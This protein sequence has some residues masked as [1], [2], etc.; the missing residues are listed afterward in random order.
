MVISDAHLAPDDDLPV[1]EEAVTWAKNHEFAVVFA[2]DILDLIIY[3]R[4]AYQKHSPYLIGSRR[5]NNLLALKVSIRR[6]IIGG[7]YLRGNHEGLMFRHLIDADALDI[8][9]GER[10]WRIEHGDRFA[11]DWGPLGNLFKRVAALALLFCPKLWLVFTKR[12][13][14]GPWK[15]VTGEQERYNHLTGTIW[16][17]ALTWAATHP[18]YAG[19]IIGHTHTEAELRLAHTAVY[20]A[21]NIRDGSAILV[22]KGKS[23]TLI[24]FGR[25]PCGGVD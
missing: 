4:R 3:G 16:A 14:P 1:L 20:D 15:G 10:V 21:G 18:E 2:G 12:W 13:R 19:I 11:M 9:V 24:R 23:P 7:R 6:L 22:E 8:K 17:G 25:P 5:R